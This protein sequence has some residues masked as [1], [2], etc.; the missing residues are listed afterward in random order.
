[1][2]ERSL[3]LRHES[4]VCYPGILRGKGHLTK[5]IVIARLVVSANLKN[6]RYKPFTGPAFGMSQR[7][8]ER[9]RPGQSRPDA[10]RCF[11]TRARMIAA[12]SPGR[13]TGTKSARW[14]YSHISSDRPEF[15]VP[16]E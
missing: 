10:Y 5:V 8:F 9:K 1:L 6:L 2:V 14:L 3:R 12:S 4:W 7:L 16:V 13:L 11:R 15:L